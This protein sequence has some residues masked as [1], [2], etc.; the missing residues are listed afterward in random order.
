L[1]FPHNVWKCQP[2][3]RKRERKDGRKEGEKI[4]KLCALNLFFSHFLLQL[5]PLKMT[6]AWRCK[7]LLHVDSIEMVFLHDWL[8]YSDNVEGIWCLSL[9]L[10]LQTWF[11]SLLPSRGS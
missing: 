2:V 7:D 5:S 9:P 3:L 8:F 11:S 10:G 4:S 1:L 6:H